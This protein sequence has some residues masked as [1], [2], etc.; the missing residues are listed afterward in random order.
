[1]KKIFFLSVSVLFLFSCKNDSEKMSNEN[2]SKKIE[3][4]VDVMYKGTASI[5]NPEN[6][7]VVM[8]WNKALISGDLV[9]VGS[10]IADSLT[11]TLAD[12]MHVELSH[13]SAVAFLNGWRSSMDSA[14]QT[15]NAIIAVDNKDAG[16][17][18][19]IQWIKETY[20]FKGGKS[21]THLLNESYRL[22]NGKIREI[23]QYARAVPATK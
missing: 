14:K 10:L 21:E 23:S 11:A 12:G 5:G 6:M 19:V 22:V 17:E 9:T 20:H 7:V 4:P 18:W 13:D 8:N 2:S 3:L 15:Y 1:M 16:D